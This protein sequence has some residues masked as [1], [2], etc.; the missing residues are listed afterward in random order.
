[1]LYPHVENKNKGK[2]K[3]LFLFCFASQCQMSV[4]IHNAKSMNNLKTEIVFMLIYS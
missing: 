4:H 2:I 1:M 3:T